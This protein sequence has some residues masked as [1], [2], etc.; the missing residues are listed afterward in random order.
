MSFLSNVKNMLIGAA[1]NDDSYEENYEREYY[2][3]EGYDDYEDE[4]APR[5]KKDKNKRDV[6]IRNFSY[7]ETVSISP[8]IKNETVILSPRSTENVSEIVSLLQAN[9]ECILNLKPLMDSSEKKEQRM[10]QRIVDCVYGVTLAL[11]CDVAR[12]DGTDT[13]VVAPPDRLI[14]NSLRE[15]ARKM[16]SLSSIFGAKNTLNRE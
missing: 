11:N 10:A 16:S 13:F 15:E 3:D 12:I 1:E 6:S 2:G 5:P 8:D 7:N 9:K 4:P 14:T